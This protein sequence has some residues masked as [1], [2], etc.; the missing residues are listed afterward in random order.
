MDLHRHAG[1]RAGHVRDVRGG[2]ARALRRLAAR[3]AR[4]DRRLRRHGRRAAAR[5]RR[6]STASAWSS[7][8]T[9]HHLERRVETR[10]LDLVAPDL[11]AAL[12]EVEEA[13]AARATAARSAS[14]ATAGEVFRALLARG[15]VPDIVTDQTTRARSA[16]R[17]RARRAHARRRRDELRESDPERYIERVARLDGRASA[18]RWSRF[19]ERGVGGLR[20][21]QQPARRGAHGRLRP[22]PSPTPASSRPTCGRSSARASGP[23]R[24]AALSGDPDDIAATDARDRRA[25]PRER[26]TCSAGCAWRARAHRLP[27][28]AGAHLLARLR[29]APPR[30]PALQRARALG[31]GHARRS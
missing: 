25:L 1:H 11:D 20:L 30:G 27:G 22:R 8:S 6:C 24:W 26:A 2:R 19:Q 31:R 21:R 29:R 15:V 9:P 17:L 16:R 7:T 13:H 18:P 4:A 5:G 10:Y 23:F 12:R 3:P 14:S 28:P